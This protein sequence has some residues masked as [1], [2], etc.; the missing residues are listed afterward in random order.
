M[1]EKKAICIYGASSSLI[2]VAYKEAAYRTGR[3][4]AERGMNLV[5]G[6][7]RSGLMA[8]AI[9]GALDA[10]G[11][12]I[13]VLPAFMIERG[14]H[15]P[16]LTETLTTSDMHERKALMAEMST[17]AIALPGGCGTLEELLEIITWRQLNLY[18]GRVVILNVN[19]Y[20]DPLILMLE[21]TIE[22]GFMHED[23]R[24][25]WSVATSPE[26][27]VDIV[28]GPAD[29]IEFSQKIS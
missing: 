25:L 12:A 6:G 28:T 14:W 2:D 5:S 22:E 18:H 16:M 17:G 3:L 26:E 9:E 8:S 23:H 19:G 15:H 7:G 13:G 27:A 21:R 29:V 1:D 11:K 4:V 24:A 10:G 20:Y